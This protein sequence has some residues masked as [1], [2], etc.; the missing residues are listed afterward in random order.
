[1]GTESEILKIA[2][3]TSMSHGLFLFR[4]TGAVYLVCTST[5]FM[6]PCDSHAEVKTQPPTVMTLI[7]L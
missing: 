1:M 2:T 3:F 6:F 4:V 5:V 7:K